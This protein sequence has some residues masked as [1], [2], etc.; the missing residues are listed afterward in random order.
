MR[1]LEKMKDPK[2]AIADKLTSQDGKNAFDKN[3][4]GHERTRGITGC[5]DAVESKFA[6]ADYVM[7]TYRGISVLNASGIVQQRTYFSWL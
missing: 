1:A 3:A 2:L 6:A 4:D 7:R 5:N